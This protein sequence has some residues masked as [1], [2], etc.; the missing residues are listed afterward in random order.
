MNEIM[1]IAFVIFAIVA[2]VCLIV[3][4]VSSA[5]I[6][7]REDTTAEG[8]KKDL[9]IKFSSF[10]VDELK[11][12]LAKEIRKNLSLQ[13]LLAAEEASSKRLEMRIGLMS[14]DNSKLRTEIDELKDLV[15]RYRSELEKYGYFQIKK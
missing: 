10:I 8:H 15:V 6:S 13:A 12:E 1:T 5:R 3:M 4:A 14:R 11:K 9:T 2:A 7:S